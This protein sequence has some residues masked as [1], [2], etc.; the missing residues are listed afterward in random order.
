MVV[1]PRIWAGSEPARAFWSAGSRAT[2]GTSS[3]CILGGVS[4]LHPNADAGSGRS[5]PHRRSDDGPV[6]QPWDDRREPGR[7]ARAS[8]EFEG[9]FDAP[10]DPCV[11][12]SRAISPTVSYPTRDTFSPPGKLT[13]ADSPSEIVDVST[14]CKSQGVPPPFFNGAGEWAVGGHFRNS[15]TAG[16]YGA[17]PHFI[18]VRVEYCGKETHREGPL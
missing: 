2:A 7:P 9:V 6:R 12:K 18:H 1:V 4:D 5:Q 17:T 11:W 13:A 3:G 15:L 16:R 10:V 8:A 14:T